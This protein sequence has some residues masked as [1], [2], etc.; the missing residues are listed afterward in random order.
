MFLHTFDPFA[1]QF[2]E[3]FGIRWYGLAYLA[4]FLLG[5]LFVIRLSKLK[6]SPIPI[7]KVGD[8]IF[9]MVLSVLLGGRLGYCLF[10]RPELFFDFSSTIPFWGVL[11][12]HEGGMA[13]H[14]GVIGFIA[15]CILFGRKHKYP[16]GHLFDLT[17]VGIFLG[18]FFG[19]IANFI[20]GELYGRITN[21]PWAVKFPGA[22]GFR[23]PSQLYEAAKNLII[24]TVLWFIR[25]K[26]FPKGFLFGTFICMYSALRFFIEF[27][28]EAD[29]QVG[30]IYG[31]TLGQVLNMV[32]FVIGISFIYRIRGR[33]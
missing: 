27:F 14:G 24:F 17:L 30:Y 6:R 13:S 31:L 18:V 28:R 11:A 12:I 26:S 29:I 7:T 25:N 21:V 15:G 3:N 5:Y 2:T 32:M 33:K 4:G 19:R 9:A 8:F 1:I 22:D 20:N 16:I 10:Y 23:H